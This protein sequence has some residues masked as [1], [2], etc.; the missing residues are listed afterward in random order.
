[1]F[2]ERRFDILSPEFH[3]NPF[4]TLDRMRTEGPVV[5]LRLPIVGRTWLA[6]S[7]ESCADL[8]KKARTSRA[9]PPTPEAERRSGY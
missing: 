4:T 7:H 1:M 3:A 9:I 8:L 5:R 2:D 6:A